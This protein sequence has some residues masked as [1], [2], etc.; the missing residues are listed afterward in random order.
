[1]ATAKLTS[2][3]Q[4]LLLLCRLPSAVLVGLRAGRSSW[5]LVAVVMMKPNWIETLSLLCM[6]LVALRA[7]RSKL[8]P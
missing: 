4:A 2:N 7:G 5:Q 1:V 6:V 3:E 8:A